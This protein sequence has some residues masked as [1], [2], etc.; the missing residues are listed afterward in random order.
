MSDG[1]KVDYAEIDRLTTGITALN[2]F[3]GPLVPKVG[4]LS[5]DGDLL[6][7]A[8]LSPGTA[9]AAEGAVMNASAQLS[10]TIVSTEALVIITA[11][12]SKVYEAA[13]RAIAEAA[14][15][16]AVPIATTTVRVARG[17]DNLYE[18]AVA[19][20]LLIQA[21]AD[22]GLFQD[23]AVIAIVSI[24]QANQD[25]RDADGDVLDRLK[26]FTSSLGDHFGENFV[27]ALPGMST[28]IIAAENQFLEGLRGRGS[29][30]QVLGTLLGTGRRFGFF[31]DGDA[32]L[33]SYYGSDTTLPRA[34][35]AG[36]D[37]GRSIFEDPD[38]FESLLD[39]NGNL[40]PEDL[41]SLWASAAQIDAMGVDPKT[42]QN[43][44]ADIRIIKNVTDDGVS[45]TVQI[46]ST[47]SW[48]PRAGD[49]PNDLTSDAIAMRY[50]SQTALAQAVR[51]A[52]EAEHVGD[53]PIML[54]GFS[55]GGIT[56]GAIA[57]DP[58]SLNVQQVVTAGSPIGA[59]DIPT[60][61]KVLTYESSLDP[62]APLDGVANPDSWTA[63]TGEPPALHT[64]KGPVSV[65]SAHAAARYGMM[66]EDAHRDAG[67]SSAY[68]QSEANVAR[69]LNGTK[70]VTDYQARR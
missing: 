9:L 48:N 3:A 59:M 65:G 66:A 10:V 53:S 4:A 67:P 70:S 52:L 40:V 16:I 20:K 33:G 41:T 55:L 22:N 18:T 31:D 19:V 49:G 60:T 42:G 39:E 11:S 8:I 56:A 36:E 5:V 25:A 7:S 57:A 46:P 34:L 1:I 14:L 17:I 64:D 47:Q 62:V 27:L 68:R 6:A 63:V 21:A 43:Q 29:Y 44:F 37:V 61:T 35:S 30:E 58:G 23:V 51:D 24:A 38:H 12:I 54:V 32:P 2:A 26:K 28:S 50:G 69:F 15:S 13:E 45:Y